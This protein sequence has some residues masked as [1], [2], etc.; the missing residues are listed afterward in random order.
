[1]I[2]L[3]L[4]LQKLVSSLV[5]KYNKFKIDSDAVSNMGLY[6]GTHRYFSIVI[7]LI[8]RVV[9]IQLYYMRGT[10][11]ISGYVSGYNEQ[12]SLPYH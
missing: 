3:S 2:L 5:L 11:L 12:I 1:M 6:E 8:V 10:T 4:E 7:F 9:K